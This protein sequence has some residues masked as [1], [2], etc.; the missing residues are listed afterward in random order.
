MSRAYRIKV[1]E[2][3]RK[4]IRASDHVSSQLEVL[5]ILPEENMAELI[6]NELAQQGFER[7]GDECVREQDGV[8]ITVHLP[9]GTIKV[10]AEAAEQLDLE[11]E[12]TGSAYDDEGPGAEQVRQRLQK[13]LQSDLTKSAD[14]KA[15]EL[16]KQVTDR[17]EAEL[18]DI[19]QELD[20]AVNR[21]TAEALKIKAAQLGQIKE[22]SEDE[23]GSLKIVV[24]V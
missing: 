22:I 23:T 10:E 7:E 16:Q 11:R 1:S 20:R 5:R 6:A 12:R 24:E 4:V 15:G 14:A 9:T 17:L 21:A 3:L 2:S 13:E 8:K 18:G 19:R